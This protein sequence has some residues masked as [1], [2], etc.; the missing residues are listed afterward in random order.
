MSVI[1]LGRRC[2][3]ARAV[4]KH[5]Q[6]LTSCH[7][8]SSSPSRGYAYAALSWR[9]LCESDYSTHV[10]REQNDLSICS[11]SHADFRSVTLTA[12]ACCEARNGDAYMNGCKLEIPT[13][14]LAGFGAR[15]DEVYERPFDDRAM[16]ADPKT[17]EIKT[18]PAT[19]PFYWLTGPA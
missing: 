4:E 1:D 12:L 5:R 14:Y 6:A 15:R 11:P 9:L 3:L 10:C 19:Y 18:C 7:L 16:A 13:A 17:L 8:P 2:N